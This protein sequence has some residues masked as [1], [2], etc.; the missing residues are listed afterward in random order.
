MGK[1]FSLFWISFFQTL[2]SSVYKVRSW[3]TVPFQNRLNFH[4]FNTL[5]IMWR[6]HGFHFIQI[7]LVSVISLNASKLNLVVLQSSD[8]IFEIQS[9]S[10]NTNSTGS[11]G[12][13]WVNEG[14]TKANATQI[15]NSLGDTVIKTIKSSYQSPPLLITLTKFKKLLLLRLTPQPIYSWQ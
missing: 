10:A 8:V 3:S 7:L 11:G 13:S 1:S 9:Q 6:L 5:K 15:S 14:F 4:I 2:N 12:S